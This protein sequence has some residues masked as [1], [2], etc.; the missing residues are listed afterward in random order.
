VW[1]VGAGDAGR[2][3]STL[4]IDHDVMILGPGKYGPYDQDKYAKVV[5]DGEYSQRKIGLIGDFSRLVEPGHLVLLRRGGR[6]VALGVVADG[7]YRHDTAY[8]DVYGW[9]LEHCRSVIWQD[10]LQDELAALQTEIPLF[11]TPRMPMFTSV[12]S[13]DVLNRI[14][15]L[16]ERLRTRPLKPLPVPPPPPLTMEELGE[17]LF[18][19]GLSNSEVDQVQ[20]AIERQRRLL[21]WYRQHGKAS[22]RPDEQE[23]VSH[24]VLPLLLAL[25]WSEQLLAVEWR[26]VDLAGFI[27]TPTTSEYCVLAC[28]AKG[29][30][31]GL[32]IREALEDAEPARDAFGQAVGSVKRLSLN[33]C[34]KILLSQGGR[35]YLYRRNADTD[36]W[37]TTPSGYLNVEKIRT[38]HLAPSGTNAVTTLMA[39]TPAGVLQ[40]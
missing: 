6:A 30:T 23:V 29:L 35:F 24:M 13:Q 9:D 28:E 36:G 25:G 12:N 27:A 19:S 5:N 31:H 4:C 3:F 34:R 1:Q 14:A 15:P 37:Q 16:L 17:A 10:H 20:K 18:S 21:R 33:R 38:E 26:K 11:G 32:H 8:D 40:P 7:G 2:D 22:N 39:L